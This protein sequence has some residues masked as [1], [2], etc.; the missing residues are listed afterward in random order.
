[1][2]NLLRTRENKSRKQLLPDISALIQTRMFGSGTHPGEQNVR[3]QS[4]FKNK[5][6]V[7]VSPQ[8]KKSLFYE[9]SSFALS[10]PSS[11]VRRKGEKA[12]A[13]VTFHL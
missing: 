9:S 3:H 8:S 12:I 7:L 11:G 10:F 13:S 2:T 5:L 4:M 6:L 1:M